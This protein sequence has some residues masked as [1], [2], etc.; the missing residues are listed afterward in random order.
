MPGI[1]EDYQLNRAYK[2]GCV[3]EGYAPSEITQRP[4]PMCL[5]KERE[6]AGTLIR[7][8]PKKN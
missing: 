5:I 2:C 7:E 8:E 6:A 4:C 3:F 1:P